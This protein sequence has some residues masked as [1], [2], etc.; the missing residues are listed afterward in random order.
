VGLAFALFACGQILSDILIFSSEPLYPAYAAQDERLFG[1]SVLFDQQLA[2]VVMMVE[3]T[4]TLGTCIVLLLVGA[5][6]AALRGA[7]PA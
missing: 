2:G 1:F 6:R 4:L 5:H 3:Q 7:E